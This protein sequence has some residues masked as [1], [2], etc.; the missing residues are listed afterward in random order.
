M[1]KH[2]IPYC[3]CSVLKIENKTLI[4]DTLDEVVFII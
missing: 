1:D 3:H 2:V 4:I